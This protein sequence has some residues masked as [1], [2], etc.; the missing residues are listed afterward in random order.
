MRSQW[1]CRASASKNAAGSVVDAGRP[2]VDAE[3]LDPVRSVDGDGLVVAVGLLDEGR[4]RLVG[5][6]GEHDAV[7]LDRVG[8]VDRPVDGARR[9]SSL[10]R[11]GPTTTISTPSGSAAVRH[12]RDHARAWWCRRRA[13]RPSARRRGRARVGPSTARRERPPGST[14]RPRGRVDARGGRRPARRGRHRPARGSRPSAARMPG[15]THLASSKL[16]APTMW[17]CSVGGQRPVEQRRLAEVVVE[18]RR[19]ELH[20]RAVDLRGARGCRRPSPARGERAAAAERVRRVRRDALVDRLLH[21]AVA[22]VVVDRRRA[23]RLI[24]IWLKFGPPRRV[25]WVSR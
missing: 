10:P 6:G 16:N 17:S 3:G 5:L 25:S 15:L 9:S 11:C 13:R 21:E 8:D 24:G 14:G 18:A 4:H 12:A 22:V 7:V 1:R 2:G 23:G 20:L 19:A